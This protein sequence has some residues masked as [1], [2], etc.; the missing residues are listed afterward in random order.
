MHYKQL[1]KSGKLVYDIIECISKSNPFDW[2]WFS[3]INSAKES[4]GAVSPEQTSA[5]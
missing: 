5:C 4:L 1:F 2:T 3:Q